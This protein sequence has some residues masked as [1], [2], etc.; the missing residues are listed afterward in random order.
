MKI[1][2]LKEITKPTYPQKEDVS[3]TDLKTSIPKR[4]IT[5]SAAKVAL[6]TLAVISLVGCANNGSKNIPG[7]ANTQQSQISTS[8]TPSQL[9]ED[10]VT[11]G[12]PMVSWIWVA[13]IFVHGEGR[14]AF[15]CVMIAP[16]VFLTE[17]E[18]LAVINEVAKEYGLEFSDKNNL[19]IDG[20]ICPRTH[21]YGGGETKEGIEV[22]DLVMDFTDE[23]HKIAIEYIS[24]EDVQ[25]WNVSKEGISAGSYNTKEAAEQL[26]KCMEF[27]GISSGHDYIAGVV[28]DPCTRTDVD[29][30]ELTFNPTE[31][32][33]AIAMD[34]SVWELKQQVKDFFEWLK[35][36]GII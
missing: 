24:K 21:M 1:Q 13:P 29:H 9:I 20:V 17:G 27:A 31:E 16:P 14:G 12:E 3:A 18:A 8:P 23:A 7:D 33:K 32:Q 34:V 15:G 10:Y 35:S 36:E 19:V 6:G 26:A 28:Y 11:V 2:P 4:W 5:C 22:C 30:T 25:K